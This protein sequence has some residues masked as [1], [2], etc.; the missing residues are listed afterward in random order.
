MPVLSY[1]RR[2]HRRGQ[3]RHL[4][5]GGG[6]YRQMLEADERSCHEFTAPEPIGIPAHA[7]PLFA[8]PLAYRRASGAA[9]ADPY[10]V[11]PATLADHIDAMAQ[12]RRPGPVTSQ[13]RRCDGHRSFSRWD[14]HRG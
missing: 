10:S 13:S 9:D 8:A 3:T 7:R 6:A 5:G 4:A 11:H 14:H 12:V 1:G 2:D